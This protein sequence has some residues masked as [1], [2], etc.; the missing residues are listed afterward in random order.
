MA[1]SAVRPQLLTASLLRTSRVG[2]QHSATR[3]AHQSHSRTYTRMVQA[4]SSSS[5]E[6]ATLACGCFWSP[7]RHYSTLNRIDGLSPFCSILHACI[8]VLRC[9]CTC[10]TAVLALQYCCTA[11][12]ALKYGCTAVLALQ[13]QMKCVCF[14]M[15][16]SVSFQA[17][18]QLEWVTQEAASPIPHMTPSAVVTATQRL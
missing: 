16:S 10:C 14:R 11:V 3:H 7:V 2:V 13:Q 17:C 15:Q 4:Q 6:T 1:F 8:C 9:S 12:L 5:S 18:C